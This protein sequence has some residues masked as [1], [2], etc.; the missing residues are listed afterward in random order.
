VY[1][2]RLLLL[3]NIAYVVDL[4]RGGNAGLTIA[5]CLGM[6]L[7]HILVYVHTCSFSSGRGLR[8][9]SI[10]TWRVDGRAV[11][12]LFFTVLEMGS[13]RLALA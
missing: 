9:F 4:G 10:F 6:V 12:E 5:Y 8:L 1:N 13:E 11:M 2:L 7:H 3:V